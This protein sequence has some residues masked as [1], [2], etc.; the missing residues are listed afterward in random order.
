V[1]PKVIVQGPPEEPV[2]VT[3]SIEERPSRAVSIVAALAL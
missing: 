3:S 2:T 1:P